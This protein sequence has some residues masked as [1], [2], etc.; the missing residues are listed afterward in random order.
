MEI[1]RLSPNTKI[2]VVHGPVSVYTTAKKIRNGIGDF[3]RFNAAT[4]KALDALEYSRTTETNLQPTGLAG[5]WEGI[6]IQLDI[7][8][9]R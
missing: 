5:A 3:T 4:Q 7:I 1:K 9:G 6:Q 2:R 8:G